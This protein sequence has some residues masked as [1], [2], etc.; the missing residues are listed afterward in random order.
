[1]KKALLFLL[2]ITTLTSFG[3]WREVPTSTS[4]ILN[5]IEIIGSNAFCVGN[6]GTVLKSTDEGETWSS[7]ST[8]ATGNINAIKFISPSIGFFTT[9]NGYIFKTT[10]SGSSW[11][12]SEIHT[13]GING[14]DFLN[15]TIGLAVADNGVNFRTTDAGANWISL[16]SV[17]IFTITDVVAIT[18][19][20]AVAV[21]TQ[22]SYL[23]SE[24]AGATWTYKTIS[25]TVAFSKIEKGSSTSAITVGSGGNIAEFD[26]ETLTLSNATKIDAE[27]DWIKD[28]FVRNFD[29]VY[30]PVVVGFRSSVHV[31]N[32]T[33]K[34]FDL[35]SVNNLNGV[36]FIN[37]S[38]GI[39]CGFNGKIYK[40]TTG[41]GP[42]SAQEIKREKIEVYPNPT[43][44]NIN[45]TEEV[46]QSELFVYDIQGKL[47][48]KQT[49]FDTLIDLSFLNEGI[50]FLRF[51]KENL[52]YS[53][54][55]IKK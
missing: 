12:G 8:S 44:G 18:E 39:A 17:S 27:D 53:G 45:V 2:T 15:S 7:I 33:W 4:E 20:L 31:L 55:V 29:G 13:G 46:I 35:D 26:A 5:K 30:R 28:V 42:V 6:N 11:S 24:D 32:P 41:A 43:N 1:M 36:H 34:T 47:V 51:R 50:Y 38:I 54:R 14:I 9:S 21:G 19:S 16:G 48:L 49:V 10:D 52:L 22:G 25:T 37:D 40:T 23:V 3:I